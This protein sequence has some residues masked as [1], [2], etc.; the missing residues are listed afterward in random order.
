MARDIFVQN[1]PESAQSVED[2]PDDWA[3]R[4]LPLNQAD[5]ASAVSEIAPE[6]DVRDPGWMQVEMPGV[7]IEIN[8]GA[9]LPL[10]GFAMHVRATDREA[11]DD[12]ISA[13]LCRLGVRAF[14]VDSDSGIFGAG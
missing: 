14:D 10:M 8:V 4:P 11:A 9:E 3:P 6:A 5:I 13:L 12:F 7:S 2:I 1:I